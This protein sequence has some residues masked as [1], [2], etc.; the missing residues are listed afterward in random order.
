MAIMN[1]T[2]YDVAKVILQTR[3]FIKFGLCSLTLAILSFSLGYLILIKDVFL[4]NDFTNPSIMKV[5]AREDYINLAKKVF[6][7]VQE[8]NAGESVSEPKGDTYTTLYVN[9]ALMLHVY[10]KLLEYYK[11][12]ESTPHLQEVKRFKYEPYYELRLDIGILIL[13]IFC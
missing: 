3:R 13:F 7:P 11:Y 1:S 2:I 8:Y 10:Y 9:R 12:D 6:E 4:P 5:L